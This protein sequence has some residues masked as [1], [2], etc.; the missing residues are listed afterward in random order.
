MMVSDAPP[1]W[2]EAAQHI[3]AP[4]IR[5]VLVLGPT[6]SG[7]STLCRFLLR[8]A[9]AR[10]PALLDADPAQKLVGPPACVTLGRLG[11][12]SDLT[13]SALAF[14]GALDPL[15]GWRRLVAGT[16]R[17]TS[18]ARAGLLLANTSGLLRGAGRRLKAA[19]IAAVRPDLLVALGEDPGLEAVLADH[20]TIP[21][22]RLPRSPL[23]RRKGEGE[24]RALRRDAFRRYFAATPIWPLSPEGIRWKASQTAARCRGHGN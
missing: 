1:G 19:K 3:A 15:H 11:A 24:R 6:D 13:L 14:V 22:L 21:A 7:K 4:G 20:A 9:S 17:L 23:A 10:D 5:R 18:E 12:D 2:K 8:T 16:E